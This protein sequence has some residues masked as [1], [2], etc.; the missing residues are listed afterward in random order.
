MTT[1]YSYFS[2]P[3]KAENLF[4]TGARV[5][6]PRM[7]IDQ[8]LNLHIRSGNL[9]VGINTPPDG[10]DVIDLKGHWITPG[11]FDLHVHFREP[12]KEVAETIATGCQAAMNG[13]FTGVGCMP[14]TNPP[15]DDA[16]AVEWVL[17]QA[18]GFPVDVNVIAAAT[19]GRKGSELVEM[20]EIV[21][22]G[23]RAF[24][25]DGA[26]IRNTAVLRHAME[27]AN[28]LGAKIFEHAEDV[29]LAADG[30]MNEGEWSTRLGIPGMPSI[31]E[32]IDVIRCIQLA[33][34]T[35]AAVHI[36]HVSTRESVEW[37]RW[38]KQKNLRVTAEVCPHHLLLTDDAC[39]DF[40]TNFKMN[41]PLRT[42]ADRQACWD[43]FMDGTLSVYCTDH[44]P[45]AWEDKTQEFD[46]AP[47]GVVGLETAL[48]L[49]LTHFLPKGMTLASLLDRVVYAP[50]EILSQSIPK[51]A[52]GELAN[53]T[54]I[55]PEFRG[56]V[57]PASFK[58]C[59]RNT[60][61]AGWDMQG[62]ARGVINRGFALI[63]GN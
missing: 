49:A 4:L 33:E 37:I 48:G 51:I 8:I 14:N 46:I 22:A 18:K 54:I 55:E 32:S 44:A 47:F 58:S 13:G 23:V 26:P 42:E 19:K 62:R 17:S 60:P 5:I 50:R 6:D 45:H 61:F 35:G 41:P 31:A 29:D 28:M 56:K 9:S 59:S 11:W 34:Y 21:E 3:E 10:A 2:H 52:N 7:G 12:G 38:A 16:A 53:L 30:A 24:S 36:C 1:K 57:D 40:D 20:S 25:D 39:R 27:Y 43:A 63:Q 15:L